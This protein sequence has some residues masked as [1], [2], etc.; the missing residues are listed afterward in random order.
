MIRCNTGAGNDAFSQCDNRG[1]RACRP[2]LAGDSRHRS[3]SR[4]GGFTLVELLVVI[5]IIGVLIG[6]L[7]PAVQAAREAARRNSCANNLKQ[8]GLGVHCYADQKV[9]GGSNC[10][11]LL[12]LTSGSYNQVRNGAGWMAQILAGMEEA[13]LLGQLNLKLPITNTASSNNGNL[14]KVK[15]PF[16]V[17]PSNS[18][19][20]QADAPAVSNYRA[21]TG[22]IDNGGTPQEA[23]WLPATENGAMSFQRNLRFADFTDGLSQTV[24]IAESRERYTNGTG[25]A[26]NIPCRWAF[27]EMWQFAAHGGGRVSAGNWIAIRAN[28]PRIKLMDRNVVDGEPEGVS[29]A[30]HTTDSPIGTT[31]TALAWGPS[32]THSG[33]QVG[34]LFS[35]GHVAFISS[36]VDSSTYQSL[37]TRNSADE[38]GNY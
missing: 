3:P 28:N 24:M 16:A 9:K 10:L 12:S 36:S 31:V 13:S 2:A 38:I 37:S 17:C 26:G 14:I 30:R 4:R 35:D 7:L 23:I 8:I 5:A 6:I 27:G 22:V 18:Q 20:P 1:D 15:L 19:Q 21:N 33:G 32:S 29:L 25:V 11:P 34:H